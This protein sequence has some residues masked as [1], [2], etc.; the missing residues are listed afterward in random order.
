MYGGV[1]GLLTWSPESF[2]RH[3]TLLSGDAADATQIFESIM[4]NYYGF[5]VELVPTSESYAAYFGPVVAAS[6]LSFQKESQKYLDAM[7]RD[8]S[9]RETV[10]E[11]FDRTPDLEKPLFVEQMGWAIARKEEER[12]LAA[13][14]RT[15]MVEAE[16]AQAQRTAD[17]QRAS[18][19]AQLAETRR[20]HKEEV[21]R[22]RK[23]NEEKTKRREKQAEATKRHAHDPQM[24]RK[25]ARQLKK[26]AQKTRK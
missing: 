25:K 6:R 17:E 9:E 3:L 23:D 16:L 2:Y 5:G 4:T 21:L 20:K 1:D 14:Q 7:E 12:R 26:R 15:K 8:V 22:L 19:S 10:Q 13:E 11:K 18:A 24:K